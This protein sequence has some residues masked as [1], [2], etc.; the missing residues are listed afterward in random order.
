MGAGVALFDFD[1]DGRLDLFLVNGAPISDPSPKGTIPQKTDPRH[2]N[3]LYHQEQDGTFKD[4]TEKAG[5][6]GTGYGMGVAV[7]DY[8][9]DGYEDFYVTAYGGNQLYHNNGDGTFTDVTAHRRCRR[10]RMVHQ[11]CMGGPRWRRLAGFGGR[12]LL[13]MGLRRHLMWRTQAGLSGLLPSRSVSANSSPGIS[14]RW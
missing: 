1:N 7:G 11:R 12:A 4:V 14:Q 6:Q 2:W 5:V 8:D 3:R 9:N 10:W 13:A